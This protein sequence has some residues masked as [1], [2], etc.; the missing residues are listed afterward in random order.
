MKVTI[1][2]LRIR[3]ERNNSIAAVAIDKICCTWL[4]FG[5]R[6]FKLSNNISF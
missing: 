6:K 5:K 2:Y 3:E 4:L 1:Y